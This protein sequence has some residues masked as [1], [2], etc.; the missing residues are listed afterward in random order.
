MRS[1]W[2]G[3]AAIATVAAALLAIAQP[4]PPAG[5]VPGQ[6]LSP[7]QGLPAGRQL[8]P[9]NWEEVRA[10]VKNQR[11]LRTQN[12]K[13]KM[14]ANAPRPSLPMLLP[15]EQS[16]LAAVFNVFPQPNS[17]AASMRMGDLAVE[18]HGDR[19]AAVLAKDDPLMRLAQG[20]FKSMIAGRAVPISIDKTEG[21]FDVT[22]SRFGAAYLIAIECRDPEKDERCLKPKFIQRIA[23]RMA[24]AG[25]D[26]P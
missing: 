5:Q 10:E 17:Y 11:L 8:M 26:S 2:I 22:F 1:A 21:G 12:L 23:E 7:N 4:R 9:I 13:L 20:Q 15:L 3:V 16:L 25:P 19:R 18:V 24:L 6:Q 14:A